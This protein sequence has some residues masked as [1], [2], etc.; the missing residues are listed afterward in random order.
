MAIISQ[1]KKAAQL[2]ATVELAAILEQEAKRPVPLDKQNIHYADFN[3]LYQWLELAGIPSLDFRKNLS[4]QELLNIGAEVQ[5]LVVSKTLELVQQ[6]KPAAMQV[7]QEV[8]QY[9]GEEDPLSKSDMIFV[10]GSNNFGR[11]ETAVRLYREQL[12][13]LIF[14][15]GGRAVYDRQ[16]GSEAEDFR[17]YAIDHGVPDSAIV[18]HDTAI[19]VPDNVRGGLNLIDELHLPH[20]SMILVTSWFAMRRS[21]VMMMKYTEPGTKLYRCAAVLPEGTTVD[22]ENWFQTE[23]GIRVIFNEFGKLK[24]SEALNSS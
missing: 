23:N 12:A 15:S 19:T 11:I 17:R 16:G 14:I 6:K 22:K 10:Y 24:I 7:L 9:L 21:W 13:P 5:P 4:W 1:R 20:G 8:T 18:I 3:L 2:P